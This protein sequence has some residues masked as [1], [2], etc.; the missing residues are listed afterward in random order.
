MKGRRTS[1]W[2]RE[3]AK[4]RARLLA[5]TDVCGLCGHHGAKTADHIVSWR[6]WP[7]DPD[8]RMFPGFNSLGNLQAAHGTMGAGR[9]KIHN[10]C[11]VCNRLCN[12]SKGAGR[13]AG[14]PV[15][16]DRFPEAATRPA[17]RK[18]YPD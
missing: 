5:N 14:A 7:R 3:Y 12:Q 8:G 10:R 16:L 15:R 11:P 2:P 17:S 1:T 18:W 6:N 4:N 13:P 9:D